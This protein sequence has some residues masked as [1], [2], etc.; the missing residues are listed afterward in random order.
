M[1]PEVDLGLLTE[2]RRLSSK[3]SYVLWGDEVSPDTAYQALEC[4]IRGV[5]RR[6][7]GPELLIKCIQRVAEGELW[8]EKSLMTAF[9][10]GRSVRLTRRESQLMKL[11]SQGLKNKEIASA[12]SI[13]EGTVKVYLSKLYVKV[14]ARDRFELA[15]FGLRTIPYATSGHADVSQRHSVFVSNSEADP[16]TAIGRESALVR[17]AGAGRN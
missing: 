13:T 4:G 8:F 17:S 2:L 1:T 16:G 9:L 3:T 11:L 12:L 6:T 14:G 5:L 15:L 7:L 10:N